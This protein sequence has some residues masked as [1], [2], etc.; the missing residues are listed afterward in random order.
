MLIEAMAVGTPAVSTDC[1]PGGAA[2]LICHEENGLLVPVR[3][4]EALAQALAF[5]IDEPQ[6]AAQ[7]AENA[8][9]IR[10]KLDAEKVAAQWLT[11]LEKLCKK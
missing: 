8:L 10:Q 2:E 5:M 4:T 7:M 9:S 1:A 6:R 3:D 11:Y